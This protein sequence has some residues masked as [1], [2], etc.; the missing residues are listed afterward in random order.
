M[1]VSTLGRLVDGRGGVRAMSRIGTMAFVSSLDRYM[2]TNLAHQLLSPLDGYPEL[3]QT[4]EVFFDK[5]CYQSEVSAA[6]SIHRNTL[7]YRLAKVAEYTALDPRHFDDAV[8]LRLALQF[9]NQ[10]VAP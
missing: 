6:L 3:I 2:K 1:L 9:R 5:D 8:Q 10:R 7:T 4:L